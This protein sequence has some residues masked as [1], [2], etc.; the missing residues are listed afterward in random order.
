MTSKLRRLVVVS[1]L[2]LVASILA[3]CGGE[4]NG[5]TNPT[6]PPTEPPPPSP[7]ATRV[8]FEGSNPIPGSTI[9]K[10]SAD[11]SDGD[12][13][14]ATLKFAYSENDVARSK[15]LT[16]VL[17]A[18]LS[19]DGVTEVPFS[20]YG[21]NTRDSAVGETR[22]ILEV[23]RSSEEVTKTEFI[24]YD[25]TRYVPDVNTKVDGGPFHKGV[26]PVSYNWK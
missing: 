14:V 1:M 25:V 3:A 22:H 23:M 18:C 12:R 10:M 15:G 26:I 16:V 11:F 2:V 4:G 17:R 19:T 7:A 21:V 20:C 8:E 13:L 24:I 6:P 9:R 5:I